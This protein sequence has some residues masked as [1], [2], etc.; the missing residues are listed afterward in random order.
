MSKKQIALL[1]VDPDKP[2]VEVAC[3]VCNQRTPGA[4]AYADMNGIPGKSYYCGTCALAK[5]DGG[6]ADYL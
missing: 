5:V 4:N 2:A 1:P 3:C 6:E